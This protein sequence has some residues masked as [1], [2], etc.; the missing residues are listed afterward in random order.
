VKSLTCANCARVAWNDVPAMLK[1]P[2][3]LIVKAEGGF[4]AVAVTV[5]VTELVE[6]KVVLEPL[7]VVV[8]VFSVPRLHAAL[9][10]VNVQ[11]P[12]DDELELA[13]LICQ[14][15]PATEGTVKTAPTTGS[16]V[17]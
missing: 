15:D 17:L 7:V 3:L 10:L 8:D 12:A 6:V 9:E 13:P 2:L 4:G 5:I 1:V 11:L 16:P 14:F